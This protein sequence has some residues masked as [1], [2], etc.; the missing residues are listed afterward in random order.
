MELEF[1]EI[2]CSFPCVVSTSFISRANGLQ[3][4]EVSVSPHKLTN[5]SLCITHKR[6]EIVIKFSRSPG[7]WS[8]LDMVVR[9]NMAVR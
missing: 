8:M 9:G 5:L 4:T 3:Y 6:V 7:G 1:T 2:R